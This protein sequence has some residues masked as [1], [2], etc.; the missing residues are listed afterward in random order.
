MAV[1]DNH[2]AVVYMM[3]M[4]VMVESRFD[5]LVIAVADKLQLVLELETLHT[6]VVAEMMAQLPN[7]RVL[8]VVVLAMHSV[9]QTLDRRID[10]LSNL[11]MFAMLNNNGYLN[12]IN[13]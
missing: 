13:E 9:A 12:L 1:V 5:R 8:L 6:M 2:F 10:H 3:D 7:H 4:F 11:E